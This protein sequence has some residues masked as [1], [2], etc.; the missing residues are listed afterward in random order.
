MILYNYNLKNVNNVILKHNT[1]VKASFS[2]FGCNFV[3]FESNPIRYYY[4]TRNGLSTY[5][6]YKNLQILSIVF[7]IFFRVILF[8]KNKLNKLS[9]IFKGF[10][11]FCI[12][13]HGPY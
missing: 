10:L 3:Y 1:G 8:E 12:S 13:K 5:F 4:V 11:H 7:K 6:K 9:Y 2:F